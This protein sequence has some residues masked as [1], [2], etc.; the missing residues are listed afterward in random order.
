MLKL[1]Q[2]REGES[3]GGGREERE[4]KSDKAYLDNDWCRYIGYLASRRG[5]HTRRVGVEFNMAR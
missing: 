1:A 4:V 5:L 2:G 3:E